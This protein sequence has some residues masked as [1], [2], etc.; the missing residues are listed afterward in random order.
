MSDINNRIETGET[1]VEIAANDTTAITGISMASAYVDDYEA[2]FA[3]YNG[4]L[5]LQKQYDMGTEACYFRI[6]DEVGLYLQGGCT[7]VTI[8]PKRARAAFTLG[9]TSAGALF[10]KL[11]AA[12]VRTVQ[13][14][15]MDMGGDYHWFQCYDPSGNIIEVLGGK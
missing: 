12:G 7:P 14:T 2:A 3:F 9:T 8:D 10:E 6:T 13:E 4:L 11:G 5:G 15:P 1:T